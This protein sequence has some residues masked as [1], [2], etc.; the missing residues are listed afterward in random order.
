[1]S[2]GEIHFEKYSQQFKARGAEGSKYAFDWYSKN[3]IEFCTN[4][5]GPIVEVECKVG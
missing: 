1:M 5:D 4:N 3:M 2:K